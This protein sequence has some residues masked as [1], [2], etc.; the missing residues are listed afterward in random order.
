M[1]PSLLFYIKISQNFYIACSWTLNLSHFP[2]GVT[3]FKLHF[4]RWWS[5]Q[6]ISVAFL[7]AYLFSCHFC[8]TCCSVAVSFPPCSV[9]HG[10]NSV[11]CFHPNSW[12]AVS[13]PL[14]GAAGKH[15]CHADPGS[16]HYSC[17][18]AV[19]CLLSSFYPNYCLLCPSFSVLVIWSRFLP[20]LLSQTNGVFCWLGTVISFLDT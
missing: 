20:S 9:V 5:I 4:C 18:H 8:L 13:P 1:A 16:W 10:R 12:L 3:L 14:I 19:C 11:A 2:V 15:S 7:R 17:F 6:V